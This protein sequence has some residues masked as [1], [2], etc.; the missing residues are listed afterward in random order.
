ML[1]KEMDDFN[2][3]TSKNLKLMT[4]LIGLDFFTQSEMGKHITITSI[5][6]TEEENKAVNAQTEIHVLWRAADVSDHNFDQDEVDRILGYCNHYKYPGTPG[7]QVAIHH[8]VPGGA[9]HIHVQ[10]W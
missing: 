3:L 2:Q 6:R 8:A 4:L 7:H 5:H 10:Y 9:A 1:E